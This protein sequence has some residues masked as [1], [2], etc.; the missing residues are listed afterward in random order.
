M[1][2]GAGSSQNTDCEENLRDQCCRREDIKAGQA[3]MAVPA[4]SG[5]QF[6]PRHSGVCECE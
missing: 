3:E 4:L 5:T 2:R 1:V 6:S